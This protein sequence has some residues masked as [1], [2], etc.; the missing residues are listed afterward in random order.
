MKITTPVEYL[1][2][3]T[4]VE[5]YGCDANLIDN[6]NIVERILLELTEL[7]GFTVVK[8]VIHHFSPIGVSGVIVIQESHI[9]IHTWPEYNYVAIDFFTC[10]KRYNIDDSISF[11]V[12]E[13]K[14]SH[15]EIK[16]IKRGSL[17]EISSSVKI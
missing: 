10:N 4:L 7:V 15:S 3:Q 6:E 12:K 5:L 14:A 17:E 2:Y 11:M 8:S 9:S 1:G 16:E 13:F